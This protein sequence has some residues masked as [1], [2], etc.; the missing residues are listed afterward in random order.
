M[1]QGRIFETGATGRVYF[2][3]PWMSDDCDIGTFTAA[4]LGES[5][6]TKEET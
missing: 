4:P 5:M 2:D 6:G 1:M 3:S